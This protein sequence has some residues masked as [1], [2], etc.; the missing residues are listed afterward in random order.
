MPPIHSDPIRDILNRTRIKGYAMNDILVQSISLCIGFWFLDSEMIHN[1]QDVPIKQEDFERAV[2]DCLDAID[3][4]TATAF[5][6]FS[7]VRLLE[8]TFQE[9]FYHWVQFSDDKNKL[10]RLIER[11]IYPHF[12]RFYR[13]DLAVP[14][15]LE[16]F[17]ME[18]LP[19]ASGVFYDGTAG[20][21]SMALRI[22]EYGQKKKV[23]LRITT[24]EVDPLLFHLSVLRSKIHGFEFQQANEDCLYSRNP[25]PKAD[26]SIMFP[27]LRGGEPV[28]ISDSL[29]CGG[30]WSYAYH[31]LSALNET[32]IGVCRIPNGALFNAKNRAF[33][34]YL[35]SLNV[36][37]AIISLPKS[38]APFS[39]AAPAMSLVVFRRGRKK[40]DAVQIAELPA[41]SQSE[42]RK[43]SDSV[44]YNSLTKSFL[45]IIQENGK[46]VPPSEL[47]ACNLSPQ[48]YLSQ[49]S[50]EAQRTLPHSS[51]QVVGGQTCSTVRLGDVAQIY[52]GINVAGLSRCRE[53]TGV[54]RLS[55]VQNGHIYT[56]DIT[57][58][59]LSARGKTDRYQ[60]QIGDIL[61]SCKGK[62]IK[63]YVVSEDMPLLLSHDFLGIRTDRTKID[64]WYLF[65]FLQSPVG[66]MAVQQ[67]QMG[68]SIPMIR[69][70]DLEHLPLHYI[71]LSLQT[72]CASELYGAD[73]LIKE[74]LAALDA[75]KQ[76]AYEQFYHKIGLEDICENIPCTKR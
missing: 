61:I 46:L 14:A 56:D 11:L 16:R 37:D 10:C 33:R 49:H 34:E 74:Q 26:L 60:I 17:A 7:Q 1:L 52:R 3:S 63:L 76:R 58:Y 70:A 31:Q 32:G 40:T 66:Q 29:L 5:R 6:E 62:A 4:K 30:D 42:G 50:D 27:P 65:Y 39:I 21:G 12:S 72:Q 75:S 9:L 19:T 2:Y 13:S 73:A 25:L 53:G 45:P 18:L 24:S 38:S 44:T 71:L 54:L 67:I 22:A 69:A 28:S 20:A 43:G 51:M 23:S 8:D 59:D 57:H 15:W 64:P 48:R 36:L 41:V 55:D 47:D 68:S 35:L